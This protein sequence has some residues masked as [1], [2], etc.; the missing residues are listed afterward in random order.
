MAW[1]L[2]CILSGFDNS[3]LVRQELDVHGQVEEPL[4]LLVIPKVNYFSVMKMLLVD[5]NF[6]AVLRARGLKYLA[7]FLRTDVVVPRVI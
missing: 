3:N 7:K 2:E 5:L 1:L 6:S 4:K